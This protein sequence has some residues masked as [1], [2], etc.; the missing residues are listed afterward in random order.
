MD[1]G[2]DVNYSEESR[3]EPE[4]WENGQDMLSSQSEQ[5][6]LDSEQSVEQYAP[7]FQ[8]STFSDIEYEYEMGALEDYTLSDFGLLYGAGMGA[9]FAVAICVALASWLVAC[10]ISIIKKGG[11]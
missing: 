1:N 3:E 9:G 8:A 7:Q 5:S 11:N 6:S 10:A 2:V 4:E